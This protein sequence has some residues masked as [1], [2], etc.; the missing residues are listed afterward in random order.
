MPKYFIEGS[1]VTYSQCLEYFILYSGFSKEGDLLMS[2]RDKYSAYLYLCAKQGIT[3]LSF[4]A[5]MSVNRA[6]SL[7]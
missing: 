4:N 7:F 2:A 3:S 1:E 5:W 6:G